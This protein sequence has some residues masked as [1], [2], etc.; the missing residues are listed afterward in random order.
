MMS[1]SDNNCM[2]C[3]I[4]YLGLDNINAACTSAGFGSVDIQR[5]IVAEVTDG[6]DNYVSAKDLAGMIRQ[7]ILRLIPVMD[8]APSLDWQTIFLPASPF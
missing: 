5:K 8:T 4:D 2:N 7:S 1:Y 3:L 6:K